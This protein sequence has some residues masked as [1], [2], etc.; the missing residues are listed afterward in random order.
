MDYSKTELR[1][2]LRQYQPDYL[3]QQETRSLI[4]LCQTQNSFTGMLYSILSRLFN[5]VTKYIQV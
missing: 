2:A 1:E 4:Q 5:T 3:T